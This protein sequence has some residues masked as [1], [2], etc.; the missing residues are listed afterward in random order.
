MTTIM[1]ITTPT[2]CKVRRR[3]LGEKPV[4]VAETVVNLTRGL[5]QTKKT[6]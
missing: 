2:S 5:N 4:S 1:A 3:Q 6:Q